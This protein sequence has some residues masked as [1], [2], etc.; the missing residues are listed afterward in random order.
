MRVNIGVPVVR[1]D[2]RTVTWLP[3]FLGWVDYHISLAM[4]LHPRARFARAWSSAIINGWSNRTT[5]RNPK[6]TTWWKEK[7]NWLKQEWQQGRSL[8]WTCWTDQV[9]WTSSHLVLVE[10]SHVYCIVFTQDHYVLSRGNLE[11]H[12]QKL[13]FFPAL[14]MMAFCEHKK[15]T[16]NIIIFCLN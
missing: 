5:H 3:N 7:G 9:T 6:A 15:I 10:R 14:F 13:D 1:T 2:G 4:G 12:C 16:E 8:G 11:V